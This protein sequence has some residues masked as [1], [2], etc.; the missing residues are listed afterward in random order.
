MVSHISFKLLNRQQL[1]AMSWRSIQF[2]H[3]PAT[4]NFIIKL[5]LIELIT[6]IRSS[7]CSRHSTIHKSLR[8][9]IIEPPPV[10]VVHGF[11]EYL[12]SR[13]SNDSPTSSAAMRLRVGQSASGTR[14]L[15]RCHTFIHLYRSHPPASSTPRNNRVDGSVVRAGSLF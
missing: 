5:L 10:V 8:P 1:K 6:L 2:I 9:N 13:L 12:H 4:G 3:P 11:L 14:A 15:P 7:S